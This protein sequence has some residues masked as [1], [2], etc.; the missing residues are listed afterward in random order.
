LY[1]FTAAPRRRPGFGRRGRHMNIVVAEARSLAAAVSA[2][3]RV[4]D[5]KSTIPI[6]GNLL[7]VAELDV[8]TITAH[9]LDYCRVE[10]IPA[11]VHEGGGACVPAA[12]IA[13][14]LAGIP[15]G[16]VIEIVATK[17]AVTVK[18]G[19]GRWRIP[20]LSPADFPPALAPKGNVR[21]CVLD[22]ATAEKLFGAA[23]ACTICNDGARHYLAGIHLNA[24]DGH[25][26]ATSTDGY[27]LTRRKIATRAFDG[28]PTEGILVPKPAVVEIVKLSRERDGVTVE[29]DG[30]IIC[31]TTGSTVYASKLIAGTFP[32]T[33]RYVRDPGANTVGFDATEMISA[34]IRAT[35]ATDAP[36]SII[37]LS[38]DEA[39]SPT[40]LHLDLKG[41][42]GHDVISADV[43]GRMKL[44][45]SAKLFGDLL[46]A[47]RVKRVTASTVDAMSP[48]RLDAPGDP[49]LMGLLMPAKL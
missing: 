4:V 11:T 20:T 10:S 24:C 5:A 17:G 46:R 48:L 3:R 34:L 28:L 44:G 41:D 13:D 14:L 35:A 30:A 12:R 18:A 22:L 1:H 37:G 19:R 29:T 45:I 43:A 40:E 15:D 7:M 16:S 47:Y 25:L 42:A 26:V 21:S 38:W 32:D 2:A 8:L 27:A 31:A 9:S 39:T 49:T 23:L 36:G 6:L 33:S